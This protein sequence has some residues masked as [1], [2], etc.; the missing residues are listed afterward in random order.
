MAQRSVYISED[1]PIADYV[2]QCPLAHR[3]LEKH[4]GRDFV[5]REDLD[6][7]SLKSAVT[8]FGKEIR[9]ILI[10]LNRICI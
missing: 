2:H 10:E 1:E 4:F 5:Q 8:L 3:V 6:K 9:S 7:T